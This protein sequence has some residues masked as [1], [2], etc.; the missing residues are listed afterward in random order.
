[1]NHFLEELN[2]KLILVPC[3]LAL[4]FLIQVWS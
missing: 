1:M 4:F 2:I 3:A